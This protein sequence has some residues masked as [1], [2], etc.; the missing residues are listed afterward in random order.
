MTTTI[1]RQIRESTTW[2]IALSV[3]MMMSGVFAMLIPPVAGLTVTV[4]F[5]WLLI[6]TGAL[7]LGFVWRGDR[8]ATILGEILL[9]LL[10][11]AIGVY[12]LAR[13]VAGLASLTLAIAAYLVVK[14]LLEGAIAFKLRPLR[15]S[16]WLLF[17]G[18]LTVVLAAMIAAA[19]PASSSWVVGVLVGVAL[20]IGGLARL[21][22]SV[23]ARRALT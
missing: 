19:W 14:G 5:G 6:F 10:Y 17:D 21:M 15:G 1:S 11:G 4:M 23:A 8:A 16:G 22:V 18:V 7:H 20:F 9:A 2:S 12:M 3:L 13:P